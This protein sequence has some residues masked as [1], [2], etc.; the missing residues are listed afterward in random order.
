MKKLLYTD[1]ENVRKMYNEQ[2]DANYAPFV[3]MCK[4]I[5]WAG[6]VVAILSLL[7]N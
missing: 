7:V 1:N 5:M 6:V 4:V 3:T 2:N